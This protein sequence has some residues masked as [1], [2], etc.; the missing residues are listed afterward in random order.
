MTENI[1][2]LIGTPSST[3]LPSKDWEE[4]ELSSF[5]KELSSSSVPSLKKE[6]SSS[7]TPLLPDELVPFQVPFKFLLKAF[8]S[9]KN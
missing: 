7:Y 5:K 1:I 2:S 4:L 9:R 8:N 3:T 6:L